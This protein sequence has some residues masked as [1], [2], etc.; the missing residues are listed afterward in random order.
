MGLFSNNEALPHLRESRP[1]AGLKVENM[2]ICK[3]CDKKVDLPVLGTVDKMTAESS[4]TQRTMMRMSPCAQVVP[5][6]VP[7]CGTSCFPA[8][9]WWTIPTVCCS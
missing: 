3:A 2:P 5:A 1:A 4:S 6:D 7:V 8:I 9:W